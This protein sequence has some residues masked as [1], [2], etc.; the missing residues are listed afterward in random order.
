MK[1][2]IHWAVQFCVVIFV[3]LFT[4]CPNGNDEEE[5]TLSLSL[6][7]AGGNYRVTAGNGILL[8]ATVINAENPVM[9]WTDKDGITVSKTDM[10]TFTPDTS[11]DYQFTFKLNAANG[12]GEKTVVLTVEVLSKAEVNSELYFDY[13]SRRTAAD[14]PETRGYTVPLGRTLVLAPVRQHNEITGAA[15]YEW[16]VDGVI[17]A[18]FSET[19]YFSF[20]PAEKKSYTIKVAARDGD[21]YAEALTTVTCTE[22]EG[23]YR[24]QVSASTKAK[25][26]ICFEFVQ[27]PGQFTCRQYP[28]LNKNMNET[29][30]LEKVQSIVDA[31]ETRTF[32]FSLGGFGGYIITGFDHSVANTGGYDLAIYGNAF[33][34]WGEA[35]ILWVMQ[36]DNG[37]GKPDDTWYELKGSETGKV[38]TVQRYSITYSY[39]DGTQDGVTGGRWTD[40]LG[41]S[42]RYHT[43]HD[44]AWDSLEG[45]PYW[46]PGEYITF[47]GTLLPSNRGKS[48]GGQDTHLA[49]GEGYV[50]NLPSKQDFSISDAVQADGSPMHLQ[51]IDF[52]KVQ[53]AAKDWYEMWGEVSTETGVPLDKSLMQ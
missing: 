30:V 10:Y 9:A 34:D 6:N 38:E 26:V 40:N 48:K 24:R 32:A 17:P 52:V 21:K 31:Y 33:T 5:K 49:Y 27:G 4:A 28:A 8:K 36:D 7:T 45:Y 50:D 15:R 44:G 37:N 39:P 12:T 51:Y 25:A 18:D 19:E 53:T 2:R 29:E 3:F 11:G 1:L 20:T 13:G 41:Q 47:T 43:G 22:P 35:G 23:T 14:S 42:G 16:T 46:V